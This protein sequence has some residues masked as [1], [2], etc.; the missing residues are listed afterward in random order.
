M[1]GGVYTGVARD[2]ANRLRRRRDTRPRFREYATAERVRHE[3]SA[4][5]C[6][7][8]RY[9]VTHG[10][11]AGDILRDN[12]GTTLLSNAIYLR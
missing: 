10:R 9:W 12:G 4:P 7:W 5:L 2:A 8:Q 11:T 1:R 3:A 6:A